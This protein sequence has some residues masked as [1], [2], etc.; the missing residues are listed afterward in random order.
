MAQRFGGFTLGVSQFDDGSR[1]KSQLAEAM[2][3]RF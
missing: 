2:P 3:K 1:A